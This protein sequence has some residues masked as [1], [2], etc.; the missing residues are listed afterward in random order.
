MKYLTQLCRTFVAQPSRPASSRSIPA[1]FV[2]AQCLGAW[3]LPQLAGQ[4]ACATRPGTRGCRPN[5]VSGLTPVPPM[6]SIETGAFHH[7]PKWISSFRDAVERVLTIALELR[8]RALAL[9]LDRFLFC[10]LLSPWYVKPADLIRI[11]TNCYG[12][13]VSI[14]NDIVPNFHYSVRGAFCRGPILSGHAFRSVPLPT[15]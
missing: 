14:M 10:S 5:V 1:S 9:N 4:E 8:N 2:Q 12:P 13:A 11:R 6:H 15:S 7:V 3:T